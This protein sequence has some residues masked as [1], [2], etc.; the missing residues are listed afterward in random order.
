MWN[1]TGVHP[2]YKGAISTGVKQAWHLPPSSLER[3]SYNFDGMML[4]AKDN[5]FGQLNSRTLNANPLLCY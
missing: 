1:D 5:T 4:T 2:I 3:M